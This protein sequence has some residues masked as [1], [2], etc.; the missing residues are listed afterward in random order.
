MIDVCPVPT[1]RKTRTTD[2]GLAD[3]AHDA[4]ASGRA[5]RHTSP[6]EG[7]RVGSVTETSQPFAV[8]IV[9]T[10][11]GGSLPT[12]VES[13]HTAGATTR[14]TAPINRRAAR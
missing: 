6:V 11:G 4:R 5:M 12:G 14:A 3:L 9:V 7:L 13:A 8:V 2:I 1:T 10:D